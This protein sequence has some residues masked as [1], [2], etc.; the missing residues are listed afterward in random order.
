MYEWQL[1]DL[2]E[3][4]ESEAFQQDLA[5]LDAFKIEM[6]SLS[7]EDTIE[8]IKAVIDVKERLYITVRRLSAYISLSLS[9]NATDEVSTNY[10]NV[11]GNKLNQLTKY[12]AKMDRFIGETQVDISKDAELAEYAFYFKEMKE[13]ANYLLSDEVEATISKL[14]RSA[15]H[16]WSSLQGYL[17]SQ[18]EIEF[19]GEAKT[20]SELR[21]LAYDANAETR[22]A[23]FEAE[24]ALYDQVK[25][26]V[27]FSLNNIKSQVLDVS[28]MRGYES[29]LEETL[30]KSRMS[31]AT[32]DALLTAIQEFLPTFRRYL[33]HKASVLGHE[34]G[35][36]F[37]D[38]FAPMGDANQ[39]F[40]VEETKTYLV[41]KFSQFAPDLAEMT[42]TFYEKDYMDFYP[43]K[44]KRGG[45]FCSNLPFIQQSRIMLN[46]DG[47]LNNVLT[48]A[49]ELGHA[50]HGT[51]IQ[52]HRPL[53]WSYSMPVAETAST[54]NEAIVMNHLLEEAAS[55]DEKVA[56]IE[57]YLQDVTQIIVDIYSRYLFETEVF[58]N[59]KS[60]FMFAPQL[61]EIMLNAQKKAYGDGLDEE[62]LHPYMWINKSHYYST[63]LSFYNF[64]YAFGGLFSRGLYEQYL[65]KPDGFVEQ[66]S[67]LLE[68]TTVASVED[69][70]KVMGLD[71]SQVDFWRTALSGIEAY[72][73]EFIELTSK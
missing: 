2:Y 50:Y 54:F 64:P 5:S 25:D 43:R 44:G 46:F 34:N 20:L 48:I 56:V 24:I 47:S 65:A 39:T 51:K 19:Q 32:L 37:Y 30:I 60:S 21:N 4:Y 35:L 29:P 57:Q 13:S 17:T 69:T 28:E 11:L 52:S 45:A 6:E 12:Q 53:N 61:A 62:S 18:A 38:L 15:G 41:D 68:T 14:G 22:K 66:Y 73:D 63:G 42:A 8:A 33:K 1:N 7:F 71:V 58:E 3:S 10:Q 67:K 59:R 9:T 31:Q 27:A 49:H 26:A 36:P 40:T 23:A 55:N 16:A 72:V 70:A